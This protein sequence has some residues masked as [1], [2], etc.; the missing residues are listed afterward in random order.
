MDD[1]YLITVRTAD[2]VELWSTSRLQF[3]PKGWQLEMRADPRR[4]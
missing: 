1:R 3:E 2:L 4:S